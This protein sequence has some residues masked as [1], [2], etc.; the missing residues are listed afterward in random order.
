MGE[1]YVDGT[2]TW[3]MG[4]RRKRVGQHFGSNSMHNNKHLIQR[5]LAKFPKTDIQKYLYL[6]F[7]R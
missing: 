5:N 3:R 7:V 6:D 2:S 1:A 4:S